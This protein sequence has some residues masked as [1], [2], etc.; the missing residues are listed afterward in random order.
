M[1]D[2]VATINE[3]RGKEHLNFCWGVFA[4][5]KVAT[6]AR[7]P[8]GESV[9]GGC[10]TLSGS[11]RRQ[12]RIFFMDWKCGSEAEPGVIIFAAACSSR[13]T[14]PKYRTSAWRSRQNSVK[15]LNSPSR[16]SGIIE[17]FVETLSRCLELFR[18]PTDREPFWWSWS[19]RPDAERQ[20]V[21]DAAHGKPAMCL[22]T[23]PCTGAR[24]GAHEVTVQQ[25]RFPFRGPAS[26]PPADLQMNRTHGLLPGT[27]DAI[28]LSV[29]PSIDTKFT[30]QT[31]NFYLAQSRL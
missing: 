18:L 31:L 4:A 11:R 8:G 19:R 14:N 22:Q 6:S 20:Q 29:S 7:A 27:R 23:I 12:G 30:T 9:A 24:S 25:R 15:A 1:R 16:T 17:E 21:R 5:P 26:N 13:P 2:T 3:K 28:K 10:V